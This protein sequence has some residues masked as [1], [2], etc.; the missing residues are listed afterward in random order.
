MAVAWSLFA[1][2]VMTDARV[3]NKLIQSAWSQ[4][5]SSVTQSAFM[6]YYD[7]DTGAALTQSGTAGYGYILFMPLFNVLMISHRPALGAVFAHL[8]LT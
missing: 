2:A 5:N 8:A 4:A 6:N 3:K 1:S 7:S